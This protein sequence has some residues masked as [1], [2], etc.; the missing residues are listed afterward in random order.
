MPT[1]RILLD[2]AASTP[3]EPC[4]REAILAA[5]DMPGNPSS[6]HAPGR[7]AK[8]VL[9]DARSRVAGVLGA[10]AREIVFT[11]SGT[12][13]AQLALRGAAY[14]RRTVSS[15]IVISAVEH[16]CIHEAADDLAHDGFDV[17]RV[18]PSSDGHVDADSFV[19]AVGDGAAVA[20]LMLANHETGIVHPIADVARALRELRTPLLCDACLGPGRIP[21]DVEA[22]GA[23][24]VVYSSHKLGGPRGVGAL[25]VRRRTRVRPLW[26]GG[27][28]EERL[29][30]GTENVAG[31]SGFAASF[32][33]VA[34]QTTERAGRYDEL[35]ASFLGGLEDARP[36]SRVGDATTTLPGFATLEM[37]GVEGEAA[38]INLDLEGI[39]VATGSACALG[40]TTPSPSLRAM[41]WSPERV[42]RTLRISI[43][44]GNDEAQMARAAA[45]VN[46]VAKRLRA[47]RPR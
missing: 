43:G 9:E 24:L 2:H 42:A 14:A 17:V 32:E 3:L 16:P 34:R 38:M 30:P 37:P 39:S 13:A 44:E 10:R 46:G 6:A 7:L 28:Q 23:D 26:N 15:R 11:A 1:D 41:G 12:L 35:L 47:M 18:A 36:W 27:L 22:L 25:Y 20:A 21:I 29:V 40:A 31:S 33:H 45:A 8:A 19:D 5:L 4:A